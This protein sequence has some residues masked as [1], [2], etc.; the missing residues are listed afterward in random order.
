MAIDEAEI[1]RTPA[2]AVVVPPPKPQKPHWAFTAIGIAT[3]LGLC[4]FCE[5][6]LAVMLVTRKARRCWGNRSIPS[7]QL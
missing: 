1:E 3:I 7:A 6:V 5:L 2:P 4:Y